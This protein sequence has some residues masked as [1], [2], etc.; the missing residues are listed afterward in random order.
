MTQPFVL[1]RLVIDVSTFLGP[2][3]A[4]V[5]A[6]SWYTCRIGDRCVVSVCGELDIGNV[7]QFQTLLR[8]VV[9]SGAAATIVLDLSRVGFI[10][11]CSAGV[12]ADAAAAA[13]GRAGGGVLRVTGLRG[14]PQRVF[15]LLDLENLVIAREALVGREG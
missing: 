13:A 10:D 4:D 3:S 15:R 5:C 12:V 11:A 8:S 1:S 9:E 2:A 7:A 14:L 6:L